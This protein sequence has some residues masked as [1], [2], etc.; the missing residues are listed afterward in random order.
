MG[1]AMIG[2]MCQIVLLVASR[3]FLVTPLR[4][5]IWQERDDSLKGG[6]SFYKDYEAQYPYKTLGTIVVVRLYS[7][8]ER[9]P[10]CSLK[11][12]RDTAAL[13]RNH[14]L[15]LRPHIGR[16]IDRKEDRQ[17]AG[18]RLVSA[19]APSVSSNYDGLILTPFG[20]LFN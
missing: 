20:D 3:I 18:D 1:N 15:N 6:Y 5:S 10:D 2:F 11:K 9:S 8:S 4:N 17:L 19:I 13:V 7:G 12:L 14:G 16:D